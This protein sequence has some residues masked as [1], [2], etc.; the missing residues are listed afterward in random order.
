MTM[1]KLDLTEAE[2]MAFGRPAESALAAENEALRAYLARVL[3][4]LET[5][6]HETVV[7][8]VVDHPH[9]VFLQ[10]DQTPR[11]LTDLE[12]GVRRLD[13]NV[14]ELI[15]LLSG[16]RRSVATSVD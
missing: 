5:K 14:R 1:V 13:T 12:A 11:R 9:P 15:D 6:V 8:V 10:D 3:D 2:R 7:P 16:L 4:L